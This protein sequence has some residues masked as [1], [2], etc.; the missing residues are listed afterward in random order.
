M[1]QCKTSPLPSSAPNDPLDKF[2]LIFYRVLS[3]MIGF[4]GLNVMD[5]NFRIT[6][7][8]V[9]FALYVVMAVLGV[10]YTV[11]A[12]DLENALNSISTVGLGLQVF[13]SSRQLA[14]YKCLNIKTSFRVL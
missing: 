2:D 5:P 11:W 9:I 3:F 13:V 4:C 10:I 1:R 7:Y 12:Y 8:T 6:T 14:M